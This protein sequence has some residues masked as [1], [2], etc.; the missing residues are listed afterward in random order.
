M[1]KITT[2]R[3]GEIEIEEDKM[4]CFPEGLIGFPNQKEFIILDH[5]PGS[6]FH[7]LQSAEVPDLAFVMTNPFLVKQDYLHGLSPDEACYIRK[8]GE[9]EKIVFV[10]V[11]IPPGNLEAMTANLLGPLVIDAET[12]RGKQVILA[13]SG[14]DIRF[15]LI[16]HAPGND[17]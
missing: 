4:L 13:N 12:R 14:Y 5:K 17:E 1:R 10:L 8:E 9:G 7:W 16:S 11:T 6:P 15:P 2:S 3:F